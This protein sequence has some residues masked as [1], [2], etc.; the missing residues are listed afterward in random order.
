VG[1]VRDAEYSDLVILELHL[2]VF[3]VDLDGVLRHSRRGKRNQQEHWQ[4]NKQGA[5]HI[6]LLMVA[7]RPS[8]KPKPG[9]TVD[10]PPA[11]QANGKGH[12]TPPAQHFAQ[13][14]NVRRTPR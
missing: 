2:V 8:Y 3:G 7:G 10:Y 1:A 13:H 14:L 6:S 11:D 9:E 5:S 12:P 4:Y